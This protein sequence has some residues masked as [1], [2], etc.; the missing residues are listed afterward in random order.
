M[1]RVETD[2]AAPRVIYWT[3]QKMVEVYKHC[4]YHDQISEF[5]IPPKEQSYDNCRDEKM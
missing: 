3:C 5:P 2:A 1:E 4:G